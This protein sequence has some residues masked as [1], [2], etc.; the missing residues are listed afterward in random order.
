MKLARAFVESAVFL[1]APGQSMRHKHELP[2]TPIAAMQHAAS[3]LDEQSHQVVP[4]VDEM[5]GLRLDG[6]G[7]VDEVQE[8]ISMLWSVIKRGARHG[9]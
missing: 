8:I 2:S 3:P 5:S 1:S 4:G 6:Q 7:S 9:L